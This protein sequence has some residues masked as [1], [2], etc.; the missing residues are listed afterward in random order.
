M[1][2]KPQYSKLLV[3]LRN[4]ATDS[5]I[6]VPE[7][8]SKPFPYG[9]VLDVGPD[10]TRFKQGDAIMFLPNNVIGLDFPEGAAY[11]IEDKSV[12]AVLTFDSAPDGALTV[13]K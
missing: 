6:V 1:Q 13:V 5:S 8:A 4:L 9:V 10:V 3:E 2:I 7:K 11:I 12:L